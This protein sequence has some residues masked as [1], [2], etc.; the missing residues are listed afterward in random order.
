[1]RIVRQ[2]SRRAVPQRPRHPE[3]NQ[4]RPTRL[5]PNNQI[6]AAPIERRRRARL[7]ARAAISTRV[8]RPRQPRVGDLDTVSKR[9]PSSE[10]REP[11]ANG[12]DL[13]QLGHVRHASRRP[14]RRRATI[15]RMRSV[16]DL[17]Q[18]RPLGRRLVGRAR[19]R[20]ARSRPPRPHRA[21]SAR[22]RGERLARARRRRRASRGRRCR[23]RGRSRPP[24]CAARRR[25]GRPRCRPR[26]RRA[27]RR[28]RAAGAGT[29]ALDGRDREHAPRRRLPPWASI[30][31]RHAASALP[32]ATAASARRRPSASSIPR[33]ESASSRAQ[34]S[35]TSSVKSAGPCPR[36]VS[37]ASRTSSALPTA[38]PSGWS[39]SV[40]R[41][42]TSRPASS[43]E[44]EH[45]LGEPPRLVER[46]HERAVAD[47]DV[48]HDRL[49]AGGEL[50]RHDRGGDQ[51][52]LVDGRRDV[53]QPVQELVGRHEV[54]GLAD[55]RQTDVPDLR[56]EL[57]EAELGAVARDRL[58]LVERAA[59]VTEAAAA[60]LPERDT[61]RRD[62]RADRQRRLVADAARRVLVDDL[63]AERGAEIDRLAAADHR[64][65]QH[66]TSRARERPRKNTAMQ[67]AAIW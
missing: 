64:V 9:R 1:M 8:E 4:E 30:Q 59:G 23:P 63:A 58:E 17:E 14:S 62:D 13:G 57:V 21:S 39:M 32:S 33:S 29:L 36:T 20:R 37:S 40:R 26:S 53:A 49:G 67:N 54:A 38:A 2:R 10:R 11:A 56:D 31:R 28:S 5:E 65:R 46:L 61:A 51:R 66:D 7:R 35:S 42:T 15:R 12:L 45:R 25:G 60:H 3:V 47:L 24:S 22:A 27:S 19:R 48:E 55:D 41:Q 44:R 43:A 6:L 50:L 52:E 18:H 16:D 34:A